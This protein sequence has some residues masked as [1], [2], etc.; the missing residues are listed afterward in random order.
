MIK[1]YYNLS[2]LFF[3]PGIVVQIAGANLRSHHELSEPLGILAVALLIGG[4]FLTISGF[5]YYAKAKGRSWI[6]GFAGV[7]G[8]LGLLV[9]VMLKDKSGDPWN[10]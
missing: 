1:R 3:I 6:W 4:T 2:F 10:T 8:L 9:L 7:A 5:G